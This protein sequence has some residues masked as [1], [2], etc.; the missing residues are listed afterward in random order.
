MV[1]KAGLCGHAHAT[2]RPAD[3]QA[4]FRVDQVEKQELVKTSEILPGWQ[5]KEGARGYHTRDIIKVVSCGNTLKE[6][7]AVRVR[8]KVQRRMRGAPVV[9]PICA[10][11]DHRVLRRRQTKGALSQAI[12][13]PGFG[14]AVLVEGDGPVTT[15]PHQLGKTEVDRRR[16]PEVGGIEQKPAAKT[17]AKSDQAVAGPA[18]RR[19]VHDDDAATLS[20]DCVEARVQALIRVKSHNDATA[21]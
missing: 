12:D 11:H 10:D 3:A 7:A 19:V 8:T 17:V 2:T 6:N 5:V 4:I 20:H 16:D 15:L 14:K 18:V 1:T 21:G 9:D 13:I